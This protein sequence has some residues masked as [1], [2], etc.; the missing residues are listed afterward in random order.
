MPADTVTTDERAPRPG[1]YLVPGDVPRRIEL[2]AV[3]GLLAVVAHLLFAQLTLILAV[4]FILTT[5]LTRWRPQWLAAPAGAGLLWVLAAG[6]AQAAAGFA[7]GPGKIA[8][9]LGGISQHPGRLA[10]LGAA[11]AGIGG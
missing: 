8:S 5:R 6:P 7:A 3:C 10:H 4:A 2:L 1:R 11:Y 9:Y